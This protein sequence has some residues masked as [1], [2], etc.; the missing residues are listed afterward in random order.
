MKIDIG[1]KGYESLGVYSP[2]NVFK[3][4]HDATNGVFNISNKKLKASIGGFLFKANSF[5]Y[6]VFRNSCVC[7]TC[8]LV[9]SL[10]V[11]ERDLAQPNSNPHFNL[12]GISDNS[13]I[14]MTKDHIVPKSKGGRDVLSNFQ[15]MCQPCNAE[16]GSKYAE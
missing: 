1:R 9:G 4:V 15:T 6:E 13:L 8:G 10:F 5:R 11:L 12:Y 7:S 2:E 14:L 3:S 16:K